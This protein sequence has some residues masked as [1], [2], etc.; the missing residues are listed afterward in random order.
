MTAL[1]NLMTGVIIKEKYPRQTACCPPRGHHEPIGV[2]NSNPTC[3]SFRKFRH[4]RLLRPSSLAPT[5]VIHHGFDTA[6]EPRTHIL[7][8][9]PVQYAHTA[10]L[11]IPAETR[12]LHAAAVI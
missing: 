8:L 11:R 5:P 12:I 7:A 1:S 2:S 6:D 4:R 9:L 3:Q 10:S